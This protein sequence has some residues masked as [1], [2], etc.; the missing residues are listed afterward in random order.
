MF[1]YSGGKGISP[2]PRAW[3]SLS[4]ND[5]LRV[6]P[7]RGHPFDCSA[8]KEAASPGHAEG[9]APF[10]SA[11]RRRPTSRSSVRR[12]GSMGCYMR[13]RSRSLSS[14]VVAA[15]RAADE[16]AA[17]ERTVTGR[18]ATECSS[19][20]ARPTIRQA[21]RHID[22]FS[23]SGTPRWMRT[24]ITMAGLE[25]LRI[26]ECRAHDVVGWAGP[27]AARRA[28]SGIPAET[29]SRPARARG[30]PCPTMQSLGQHR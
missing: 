25:P 30:C 21:L 12:S 24:V 26:G 29:A 15:R 9:G 13:S 20:H 16:R 8:T 28:S 22:V 1:G 3:T 14:F 10:R 6:A 19:G 7:R 5:Q 18:T 2:S 23:P 11:C 17:D 27:V 4:H